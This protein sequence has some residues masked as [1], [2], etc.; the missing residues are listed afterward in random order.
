MRLGHEKLDD[1]TEP[2][3][4][5]A[6]PIRRKGYSVAESS[7]AYLTKPVAVDPDSYF[8]FDPEDEK[9]QPAAARNAL[10]HVREP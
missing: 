9:P 8:D 10:T 3:G 1:G 7:V 6:E 5:D 2:D 4:R